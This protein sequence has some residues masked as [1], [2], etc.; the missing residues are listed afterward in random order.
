MGEQ[1]KQYYG[2]LDGLR[3]FAILIIIASHT[4]AF[5]LY[6]QGSAVVAIFF[7]LSGFLVTKPFLSLGEEEFLT[8][9]GWVRYYVLRLARILPLYW[10]LCLMFYWISDQVFPTRKVLL[11]NLFFLNSTGP[12]WFLQHEM[13][14]YLVA[15]F[16]LWMIG[17][18]KKKL[19]CSN[20]WIAVILWIGGILSSLI[21]FRSAFFVLS[22]SGEPRQI[23]L[24]LFILGMAVGYTL[25]AWKE[26]RNPKWVQEHL[27]AQ[28]ICDLLLLGLLLGISV[29]GTE[30]MLVR[31]FGESYEGYYVGWQRPLLCGL[32]GCGILFLLVWNGEGAIAKLFRKPLL[33]K[34]GQLSYGVFLIHY[35]LLEFIVLVPNKRFVL[36]TALS[37]GLARLCYD[38]VEQPIYRGVKT[39]WKRG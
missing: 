9:K 11:E 12:L 20:A 33:V 28:G 32:M 26:S 14:N 17:V 8:V 25:K 5:G 22:W 24:G 13:L 37:F 15:P 39:L 35:F 38:Y 7:V 18:L 16:I 2:Q 19:H 10:G 30:P 1:S 3:L 4:S 21:F 6:G 23:R 27:L 29:F 34:L 36:L 31:F